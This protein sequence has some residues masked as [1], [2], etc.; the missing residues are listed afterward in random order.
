MIISFY[1]KDFVGLQNNASLLIDKNSY[2]L[3]KRP[4]ELNDFSCICEAFTEDI[5]PTL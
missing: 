4:I 1:N 5:Q 2:R 3:I